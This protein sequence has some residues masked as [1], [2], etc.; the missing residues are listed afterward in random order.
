M[1]KNVLIQLDNQR[2]P[3]LMLGMARGTLLILNFGTKP[4]ESAFRFHVIGHVIVT[5]KTEL[6]LSCF[7]KQFMAGGTLIFEIGMPGNDC[8]GHDERLNILSHRVV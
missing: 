6:L 7:V 2:I 1:V 5:I 8:A 3:S 4:V